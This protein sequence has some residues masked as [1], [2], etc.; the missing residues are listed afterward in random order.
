MGKHA[1]LSEP[2]LQLKSGGLRLPFFY[3][4]R[5]TSGIELHRMARPI[6]GI[7]WQSADAIG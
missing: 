6:A 3:P 5:P 4:A 7:G 1:A 2:N